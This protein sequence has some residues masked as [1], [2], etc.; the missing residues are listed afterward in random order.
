VAACTADAQSA[1]EDVAELPLSKFGDVFV[2]ST[3]RFALERF[4]VGWTA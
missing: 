1:N 4:S 3:V 2:C